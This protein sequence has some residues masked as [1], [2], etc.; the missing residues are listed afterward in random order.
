MSLPG[1]TI[2][3]A[4]STIYRL[5]R[6]QGPIFMAG[7]VFGG[8]PQNGLAGGLG[9]LG[10][11]YKGVG[12]SVPKSSVPFGRGPR[13]VRP[14]PK[15]LRARKGSRSLQGGAGGPKRIGVRAVLAWQTSR[16]AGVFCAI[17]ATPKRTP[18]P[19]SSLESKGFKL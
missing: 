3:Q 10:W 9:W 16:Q 11:A 6:R 12:Y 8:R 18:S 14:Q 7:A 13:A 5:P 2:L 4:G 19:N 17:S 15:R 1:Q